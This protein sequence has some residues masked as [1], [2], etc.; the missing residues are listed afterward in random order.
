M[1]ERG[2]IPDTELIRRLAEGDEAAFVA[3]FGRYDADIVRVIERQLRGLTDREHRAREIADLLWFD[4]INHP[5]RLSR[6]DPS[7]R[8]LSSFLKLFAWRAGR[9][10]L[11]RL[12][13]REELLGNDD[14]KVIDRSEEFERLADQWDDVT[15][16]LPAKAL[17]RALSILHR[18][19]P[20]NTE[21][22]WL[23]CVIR[24]LRKK[25]NLC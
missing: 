11:R 18:Q 25:L 1:A 22:H 17:A 21:Q 10:F 9:R 12:P 13:K 24:R 16:S 23:R 7:R 2:D 14:E 19:H 15:Q 6:H 8:P 5:D 20:S 3:L 4:L